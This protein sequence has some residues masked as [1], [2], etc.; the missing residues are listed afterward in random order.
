VRGRVWVS[1]ELV[2]S[3]GVSEGQSKESVSARVSSCQLCWSRQLCENAKRD[4]VSDAMVVMI[5]VMND[6]GRVL[7]L[8][9]KTRHQNF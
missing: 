6:G 9:L 7:L 3:V 2:N 8:R 1:F 5:M 4:R